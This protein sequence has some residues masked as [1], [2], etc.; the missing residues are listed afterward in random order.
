MLS[1]IFYIKLQFVLF[2]FLLLNCTKKNLEE[3]D[4]KIIAYQKYNTMGR[5]NPKAYAYIDQLIY[6]LIRVQPNGNLELLP[7]TISDLNTLKKNKEGFD[8]VKLLIGVGGAKKNSEHFSTLA[9]SNS[10]RLLFTKKIKEFCFKY[11]LDGADIDWEYPKNERDKKNALILFKTL[12][13]EF[14]ASNLILTAAF[15]YKTDQVHF[16][17]SIEPYI[18]QLH[19]MAYEPIPGLDTFDEQLEYAYQQIKNQNLVHK[20]LYIGLP[21]YGRSLID[22]KIIPYNKLIKKSRNKIKYNNL[23]LIDTLNIQINTRKAKTQKLG[24]VMF[25]ELGFDC[26]IDSGDSLLKKIYETKQEQY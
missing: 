1:K 14:T 3:N 2:S 7:T 15:N 16:A 12:K 26:P 8:Q 21:F 9:A 18:D 24:G 19:L 25:W 22:K 13:T 5:F 23:D 4:I 10:S 6:K 11:G 17:K 20:K